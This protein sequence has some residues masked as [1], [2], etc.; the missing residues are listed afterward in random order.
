MHP[1]GPFTDMRLGLPSDT[2][3]EGLA[4][5]SQ[6]YE[7]LLEERRKRKGPSK[8]L[9]PKPDPLQELITWAAKRRL[10]LDE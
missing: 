2:S 1:V 4:E 7:V 5:Y 8:Q 10:G 6:K 9:V 3:R